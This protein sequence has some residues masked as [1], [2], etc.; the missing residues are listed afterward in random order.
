MESEGHV[1]FPV[2]L[3]PHDGSEMLVALETLGVDLRPD[4]IQQ[5]PGRAEAP[6]G[7]VVRPD[8]RQAPIAAPDD[9]HPSAG[10]DRLR[11]HPIVVQHLQCAVL[12]ESNRFPVQTGRSEDDACQK[13]GHVQPQHS[14]KALLGAAAQAERLRTGAGSKWQG[15][16]PLPEPRSMPAT[17]PRATAAL[18]PS[19]SGERSA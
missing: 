15:I 5:H 11:I 12:G 13:A 10:L 3:G 14:F 18:S 6:A 1:Q 16:D 8:P 9:E 7:E 2:G 19:V 4:A 17:L